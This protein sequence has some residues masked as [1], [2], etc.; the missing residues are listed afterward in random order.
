VEAEA[1]AAAAQLQKERDEEDRAESE[2]VYYPNVRQLDLSYNLLDHAEALGARFPGVQSLNVRGNK[3]ASVA[4]FLDMYDLETL[5]VSDNQIPSL[6]ELAKLKALGNLKHLSISGNVGIF[7]DSGDAA[8]VLKEL[9]LLLP[10]LETYDGKTIT[11]ME[12]AEADNLRKEREREAAEKAEEE[13]RLRKEAEDEA[14]E[15]E[16]L[17]ED[18]TNTETET[19]DEEET[20]TE[21]DD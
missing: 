20:A 3:I 17:S 4:G 13:E 8:E 5:N 12:R 19:E 1:A 10:R 7:E 16:G 15:E 14:A 18:E 11:H 2:T 21:D 6:K 9:L